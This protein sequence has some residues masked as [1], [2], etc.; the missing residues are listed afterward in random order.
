M[1]EVFQKQLQ[2]LS[3]LHGKKNQNPMILFGKW[4][5]WCAEQDREIISGPIVDVANFLAELFQNGYQYCPLNA[6]WST[7]MLSSI[8][9]KVDGHLVG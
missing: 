8:H 5:H 3:Y 2:S 7:L 6:Y 1:T 9:E 4:A